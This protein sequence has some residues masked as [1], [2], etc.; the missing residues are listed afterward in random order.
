MGFTPI[1]KTKN[2]WR[3]EAGKKRF[4]ELVV[5]IVSEKIGN[6]VEIDNEEEIHEILMKSLNCREE[7][8]EL[9]NEALLH[10][11]TMLV[12]R[13]NM[14]RRLNFCKVEG[15]S[16]LQPRGIDEREKG[17]LPMKEVKNSGNIYSTYLQQQ[18]QFRNL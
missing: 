16:R 2:V 18:K 15:I 13:I 9:V 17:C 4:L 7:T 5:Q 10:A 3:S 8:D 11:T 6:A 1:V 12:S 14:H